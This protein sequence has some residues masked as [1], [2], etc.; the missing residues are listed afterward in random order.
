MEPFSTASDDQLA[1]DTVPT[2]AATWTPPAWAVLAAAALAIGTVLHLNWSANAFAWAAV[3]VVLVGIAAY[4]LVNRRIKN[5]VTLP[6]ALLALLLRAAFERSDFVEVLVAGLVAFLAFFALAVFLR[7]GLGMGDV[8]L[9]GMLG[10]LLGGK[11]ITALFIGAIAGG[12]AAGFVLAR[13][14]G[15]GTTMAY[16]PYLAFG[17]VV[18]I[19]ISDPPHLI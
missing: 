16:G 8:K 15:R 5:A 7:G 13:S 9:A 3:Q 1:T 11:V 4:D 18:A 19:L 14:T 2:T 17:A 10:F 12:I 6:V